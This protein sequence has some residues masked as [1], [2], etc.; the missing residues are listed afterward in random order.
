MAQIPT[1]PASRPG[2]EAPEAELK[3]A[4]ASSELLASL[5]AL[6]EQYLHL[7]DQQQKLQSGLSKHLSSGFLAL[8]HANY[9]CPP[10]RRYGRD[11][12]DDRMKTNKKVTIQIEKDK[13]QAE[14]EAIADSQHEAEKS[15]ISDLQYKFRIE[16]ITNC[17]NEAKTD[18]KDEKDESSVESKCTA[19]LPQEDTAKNRSNAASANKDSDVVTDTDKPAEEAKKPRKKFRSDDPIYWYGILVPPSLRNTQKSFTEGI[20]SQVAE[21][22][23]TIV[24]MRALEQRITQL[25]ANLGDLHCQE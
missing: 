12:Y 5:D 19:A 23:G 15:G 3:S 22:A 24:E 7:L 20:Q 18:E 25:R 14:S 4:Q 17:D 11:Y 8:A 21:L 13:G 1:P 10:G 9:T 6:L 16:T 2:S